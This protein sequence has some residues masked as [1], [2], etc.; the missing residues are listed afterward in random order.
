[1]PAY[2]LLETRADRVTADPAVQR[3]VAELRDGSDACVFLGGGAAHMIP[4][5]AA[6]L[7]TA[8]LALPLLEARGLRLVVGDGGTQA[9]I[10]EAAGLARQSSG[11]AFPLVGVVPAAEVPPRGHTP[12]DPHHSHILVVDN[13]AWPAGAGYWGSETQAMYRLFDA[14]ARDRPSVAVLANGGIVALR[15]VAENV[16]AGRP[17]VLLDGSGRAA[18][19]LVHALREGGPPAGTPLELATAIADL[20]LLQRPDLFTHV[21]VHAPPDAIVE[22]LLAA[23]RRQAGTGLCGWPRGIVM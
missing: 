5:D 12:L 13:P 17:V 10:M 4:S 16:R 22:A 6:A 8:L 20:A 21:S 23:L 9:G 7:R 2:A 1:M 3:L 19:A 15:E 18:D 14:L 11:A